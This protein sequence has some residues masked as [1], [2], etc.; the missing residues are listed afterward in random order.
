[1]FALRWRELVARTPVGFF[2]GAEQQLVVVELAEVVA[3]DHR[4]FIAFDD[5]VVFGALDVL[6]LR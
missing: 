1:M 2:Y 6:Q 4:A 5:R 3:E